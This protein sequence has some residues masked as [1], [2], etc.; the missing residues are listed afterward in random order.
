MARVA[1]VTY[2]EDPAD[3]DPDI[4][5]DVAVAALRAAGLAAEA[6]R[7]DDPAVDWAAV[8]LALVRSPW[9]YVR[10]YSEFLGWARSVAAV[11]RLANP[12]DV[13]VRNTDKRYLRDL[14]TAGVPT[15]P[16][17]WL[18]PGDPVALD[19]VGWPTLVVK[20]AV[21]AGARDT[22][23]TTDRAAATAHAE[24]LLAGGRGVLVQPYL[25]AVDGEGEVA[26]VVL[27]GR[28]SHAVRKVPALTEGGH[29]D[30]S[31]PY[32]LTPDLLAAVGCVLD[33]EP[34]SRALAYAR[35]DLVRDAAGRW[36]LMELELTEPLLFLGY[37]DGA[38]ERFAAAV[39]ALLG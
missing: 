1:Y 39:G 23:A 11:T 19:G 26:V 5:L 37:A 20:P 18:D 31:R 2:A 28:P 22:L 33:A 38:P 3:P 17:H 30:P 21:G 14:A 6:V 16:T 9:D 36:V 27:G 35:V 12:L 13:I 4:D 24:A 32:P 34:G 7:W 29:G 25:D 10:R 8:D 15:V